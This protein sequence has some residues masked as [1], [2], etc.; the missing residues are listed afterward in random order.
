MTVAWVA[1]GSGLVGG[2][3]LS[4]LL[5]D[6]S[7]TRVVAFGR[8]RL[9]REDQRLAQVLVADFSSPAAPEQAEPP[10]VAFCCLGTTMRKAGSREAFRAVDHDA[11]LAFARAAQ[12]RGAR[13][14][15]HVTAMGANPR[16]RVFYNAVKGEAEADVARLGIP[17]VYAFR[18]SILDGDRQE[19]RPTE[20]V[21]LVVMRALGPLL[22]QYRPT[23]VEAVAEAMIAAAKAPAPGAHAVEAAAILAARR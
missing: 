22:G 15:L 1:G 11:V 7:F 2:A 17:S 9:P 19:R 21:G 23:P 18:P 5:R 4:R 20:Q 3:L 14:F 12:G 16:S 8:R 13:V 10:D 6:A